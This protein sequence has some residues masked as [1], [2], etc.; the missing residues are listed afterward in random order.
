VISENG[1]PRCLGNP[2]TAGTDMDELWPKVVSDF[3]GSERHRVEVVSAVN[4]PERHRVIPFISERT[5]DLCPFG[6]F[7]RIFLARGTMTWG[8]RTRRFR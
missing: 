5:P 4:D 6:S 2:L 1:M 7:A 3:S 8:D